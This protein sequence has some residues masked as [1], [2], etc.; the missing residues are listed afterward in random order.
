MI[1]Q[2]SVI[3]VTP[4]RKQWS[5][6][7]TFRWIFTMWRTLMTHFFYTWDLWNFSA[8][9][10]TCVQGMRAYSTCV[11]SSLSVSRCNHA[12]PATKFQQI[13]NLPTVLTIVLK[14][15]HDD[16][17]K[18][19]TPISYNEILTVGHLTSSTA[20]SCVSNQYLLY[21]VISHNSDSSHAGHYTA[22]IRDN[23]NCWWLYN[24]SSVQIDANVLNQ[25]N[26]Y[27]LFYCQAEAISVS[28]RPVCP[29]SRPM[30]WRDTE[31]VHSTHMW[32]VA[33]LNWSVHWK[34]PYQLAAWRPLLLV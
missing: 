8:K 24:D 32:N 12:T 20:T 10:R 14:R 18:I 25:P 11:R 7:W 19:I 22:S 16:G 21:A 31:A 4:C 1:L 26:A 34:P 9:M 6:F 17:T 29:T 15:F 5:L 27:M 28:N 30:N 23:S 3:R 2:S 33:S 13:K